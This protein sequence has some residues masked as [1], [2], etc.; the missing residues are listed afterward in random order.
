MIDKIAIENLI[1]V[2][3]LTLEYKLKNSND[4]ARKII[5]LNQSVLRIFSVH[6]HVSGVSLCIWLRNEIFILK[7]FLHLNLS[8]DVFS[9]HYPMNNVDRLKKF[10]IMQKW[11]LQRAVTSQGSAKG[12]PA[13]EFSAQ[14]RKSGWA[15][16]RPLLRTIIRRTKIFLFISFPVSIF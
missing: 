8:D 9:S 5:G 12:G 3:R 6:S 2:K 16:C 4:F 7:C 15:L 1:M 10:I 11:I 14:S 13:R